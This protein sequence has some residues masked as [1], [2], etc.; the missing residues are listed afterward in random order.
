MTT[1]RLLAA[2][3]RKRISMLVHAVAKAMSAPEAS[4]KNAKNPADAGF[5]GV[6]DVAGQCPPKDS[7][8]QPS[9]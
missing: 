1:F 4:F 8:L 6:T 2:R 7:N 5:S 9:D 3:S